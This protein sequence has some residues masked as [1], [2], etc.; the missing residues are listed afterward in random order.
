MSNSYSIAPD[1]SVI[2]T[3]ITDLENISQVEVAIVV[4]TVL[5][6]AILGV[7]TVGSVN[8][9]LKDIHDT[10]LPLV[11]TD[12]GNIRSIDVMALA[13]DNVDLDNVVDAV[14]VIVAD[15]H[16]TDL[17]LVKTDTGNIRGTDVVD[18]RQDIADKPEPLNAYVLSDDLLH[19]ND[20]LKET[21]SDSYV[22]LKEIICPVD[23]TLRIK[24]DMRSVTDENFVYAR[25]YKND[26]EFGT[27]QNS[28]SD[29]FATKSEDLA[30]ESG[31]LIQLYGKRAGVLKLEIRNL[32]IYGI[33]VNEFENKIT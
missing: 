11:K 29:V 28:G 3:V 21:E 16:D 7:P 14:G 27:E 17:P 8:D 12:T 33:L 30:F 31:D 32:R 22:I 10:D 19:S 13:S 9:F 23:V 24:F 4:G 25:I 26:V 18:I 5:D 2:T 20:G 15:I 1:L 6:T